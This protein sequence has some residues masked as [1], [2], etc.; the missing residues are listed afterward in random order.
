MRELLLAGLV[1]FSFSCR[2]ATP[3]TNAF[4]NDHHIQSKDVIRQ[5]DVELLDLVRRIQKLVTIPVIVPEGFYDRGYPVVLSI[6]GP[7]L[8]GLDEMYAVL[9]VA[10]WY[11]YITD[12]CVTLKRYRYHCNSEYIILLRAIIPESESRIRGLLGIPDVTRV[13]KDM[14][15][16]VVFVGEFVAIRCRKEDLS[17]YSNIV[18]ESQNSE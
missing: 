15:D 9:S 17:R 5:N 6:N 16:N 13:R 11:V 7:S 8:L 3:S 4:R 10:G 2:T 1:V 12:E 18:A 14:D